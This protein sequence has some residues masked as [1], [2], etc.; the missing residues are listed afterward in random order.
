MIQLL[1]L[2]PLLPA[3]GFIV[4]ALLGSRLPKKVVGMI[5]VTTVGASFLVSLLVAAEFLSRL[6]PSGVFRQTLYTWVN[7]GG[8]QVPF[9]LHLDA[10]SLVMME[11]VTFVGFL[12][13]LYASQS[14]AEEDGYSRFFAYINLFVAFM[15]VLVLAD[16]LLLLYLG[17]EGVGLCSYL[18]IGFWYKVRENG[19]AAQKAFIVTRI[20]DTSLAI[21]LFLLFVN[22]H[23]FDIQQILAGARSSWP[24]GSQVAV[25]T[26]ALILGGAVGKSGQIPLHV[27]LPD[28]M[29]G[30]TP[31]SALIHAATMVTAG[32]YLITRTHVLFLL[33]PSVLF[34]VALVGAVTALYAAFSALAQRDINRVL[35]YSTI[36]QIGYMFLALGVGAWVAAIFHLMTHAFF[37]ALLFLSAG[38][39]IDALEEEHDLF[40]MGGLRKK[41]PV[42]FWTF[43]IGAASLSSV[44]L[45]TAGFF[46]KDNIL[47]ASWSSQLG[48]T[49]FWLV[50]L[51]TAL[52]TGLYAFRAVFL[53]FFGRGER[54]IHKKPRGLMVIALTILAFFALTAGYIGLPLVLGGADP[55]GRFL[56]GM[57]P[58]VPTSPGREGH[59]LEIEFMTI[60]AM[61][62]LAGISLAYLYYRQR[63]RWA[64]G[65]AWSAVG[66]PLRDFFLAG[67]GFDWLYTRLFVR[68]YLTLTRLNRRDIIDGFFTLLS[69]STAGANRALS[70]TETG[71]V[72]MYAAGLLLGAILCALLLL[73]SR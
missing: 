22:F 3:V 35:A 16:N 6:G 55:F 43:L 40:R 34:L 66:M 61:V 45:I 50:A 53:A 17:W 15:L 63:Y 9:G 31:V 29:A 51:I 49:G 69:L 38:V 64:E 30:P 37:K 70:H 72:R 46:S 52:L 42:A 48:G 73:F 58:A 44:P 11:V 19:I 68:P 23:T 8:L 41:L 20:G 32:V 59:A 47:W 21:G 10:L 39:V 26:A 56:G 25:L 27:W 13:H 62:S 67:W 12:I 57:L 54:E 2:V 5:G 36:S 60:S 14:M 33:A 18:L 24:I 71:R 28:A 7:T 4:L 1:W 65:T